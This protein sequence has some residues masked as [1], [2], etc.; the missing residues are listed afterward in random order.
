[1][2]AKRRLTSKGYVA[3]GGGVCPVCHDDQIEGDSI[4]V[5]GHTCWQNISCLSCGAE[6]T[7]YYELAGY[8]NLGIKGD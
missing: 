6:W 3:K 7:D 8:N 1:M 4:E 2:A 5:D